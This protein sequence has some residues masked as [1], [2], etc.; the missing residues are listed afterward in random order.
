MCRLIAYSSEKYLLESADIARLPDA[1]PA[2]KRK[3]RKEAPVMI[4]LGNQRT[5]APDTLV[6]GRAALTRGR[7]HVSV[8]VCFASAVPWFN[9]LPLFVK[10]LRYRYKFCGTQV[11]HTDP[12][13]LRD[14]GVERA[15]RTRENAFSFKKKRY[16]I[17]P[18]ARAE[19][20]RELADS[21]K[22]NGF[23]DAQPLGVMLCRSAG[24]RDAL[25]N[26]HHRLGICL[27]CGIERVALTFVAA[28]GL[29]RG[30]QRFFLSRFPKRKRESL[31]KRWF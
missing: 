22:Q 2:L 15:V 24:M 12:R 1:P 3:I 18:A 16:K 19:R 5:G 23:D 25:D 27:E 11:Y 17:P 29:P 30:M 8:C 28:G 10:K 9:P 14:A 21:L 20:W 6:H 4:L 31:L 7:K 13:F 26:G